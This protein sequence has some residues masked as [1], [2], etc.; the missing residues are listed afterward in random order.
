MRFCL[1]SKDSGFPLMI[2][3]RII[4]MKV[5]IMQP[6][7]FP[8]IG[9]WQL[10]NLVDKFV[11]LD[12]V[13]YIVR[14]YINRNSILLNG[15]PYRFT[16]PIEKASQN[17]LIMETNLYF[18]QKWKQNFLM[19]IHNAY[20]KSPYYNE[21]MP[22]IENVINNPEKHLTTFIK[23]SIKE[24]IRYLGINTEIL[25]SSEI[26]KD[27]S[28]KGEQRIIELCQ[29]LCAKQY[30]N[31]IGGQKLYSFSNFKDK[32]IKLSFLKTDD[33]RYS[34]Y[35]KSFVESLSI[36]DVMMFN[37]VMQIKEFLKKYT[38]IDKEDIN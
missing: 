25:I 14:G 8:Y 33:I 20:K 13:N 29:R 27:L 24:I 12:D 37:S 32:G 6:Y 35:R 28:L 17:K 22:L 21:V 26:E 5:G 23:Y 2:N 38:I 31:A 18:T 19:T 16:I 11:L 10:I 4:F 1:T 15:K 9:Y 7:I 30:I 3:E 34:Q 36:I